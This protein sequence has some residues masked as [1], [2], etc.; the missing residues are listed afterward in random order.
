MQNLL[1]SA[2]QW[3]QI[4]EKPEWWLKLNPLGKVPVLLVKDG[5]SGTVQ[6]VYESKFG[7]LPVL[8]QCAIASIPVPPWPRTFDCC[9]SRER[10]DQEC[11][12]AA[13]A[14]HP[15]ALRAQHLR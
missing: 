6:G 14:G 9:S 15:I 13:D 5:D 12:T 7:S 2:G 10:Q 11:S 1:R 4:D 3:F 8:A